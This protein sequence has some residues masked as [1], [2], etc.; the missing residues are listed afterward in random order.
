MDIGVPLVVQ[1]SPKEPMSVNYMG[2]VAV[3]HVYIRMYLFVYLSIYFFM[4]L[5]GRYKAYIR[6]K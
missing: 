2:G 1:S 6:F 4:C 5:Y 3:A